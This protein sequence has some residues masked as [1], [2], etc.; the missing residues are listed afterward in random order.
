MRTIPFLRPAAVRFPPVENALRDPNG[1]LAVGGDLGPETLLHAYS[2]GI[3]PWYN[4][5]D[6]ILWW[7]P[8]PRMI[9]LPGRHR[10]TR[11]LRSV[12]RSGRFAVTFDRAFDRVVAACAESPR[13]GKEERT[14]ITGEMKAAY[15]R[16]HRLGHAH[17]VE[18]WE[19]GELAGGLYGIAIGACF[20]GESMFHRRANASKVALAAL[21]DGLAASGGLVIDCQVA[22]PHLA[23]MGGIEVPRGDYMR[24]L[25]RAV[26][27]RADPGL[28]EGGPGRLR[29]NGDD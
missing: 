13:G 26:A 3:F 29:R 28:W 22:S 10:V 25:A 16:L 18:A 14:W 7:H 12:I 21:S 9:M 17:S 11:S 24:L 23:S 19:D 2:L 8:D 1:L 27:A 20:F 6:P 4:E 15:I 5:G